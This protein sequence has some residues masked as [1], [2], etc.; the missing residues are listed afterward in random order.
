MKLT[1]K[2]MLL[3]K[4]LYQVGPTYKRLNVNNKINQII[5]DNIIC[6]NLKLYSANPND[7]YYKEHNPLH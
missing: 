2:A 4:L 3:K 7:A 1:I 5:N 6:Y